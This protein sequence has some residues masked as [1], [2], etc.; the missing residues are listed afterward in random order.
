GTHGKVVTD[1]GFANDIANAVAVQSNG[2]I[3]VGGWAGNDFSL[4]RYNPDGS[5]DK[6]FGNGGKV[7]TNFGNGSPDSVDD[8]DGIAIEPDGKIVAVG[9]SNGD[10][11]LARYL[12]NG[13]PDN[14]FGKGGRV[15]TDFGGSLDRAQ[16]VA[17]QADGRIV[18][19]G[20]SGG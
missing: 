5:L 12:P 6:T 20:T 3:V 15:V 7:T 8:I 2:K 4:A 13:K 10:F 16:D 19:V 17:L 11:A 14:A 1:F 18:V 9:G